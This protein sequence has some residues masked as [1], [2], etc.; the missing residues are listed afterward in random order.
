[1]LFVISGAV[2]AGKT[3]ISHAVSERLDNLVLLEEDKLQASTGEERSTNLTYWIDQ[4]LSI[5]GDGKDAILGTQ[6]PLGEVLASQTVRDLV[7]G[8]GLSFRDRGVHSLEGIPGEWRLY[9]AQAQA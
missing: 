2:A 1:M 8:S 3:T 6:A 7:A 9:A 4:T 5:E